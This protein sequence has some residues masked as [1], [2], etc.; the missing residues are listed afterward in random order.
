[1]KT[2]ILAAIIIILLAG[3]SAGSFW[4]AHILDK[5]Q[6]TQNAL[7]QKQ[8]LMLAQKLTGQATSTQSQLEALSEQEIN[9]RQQVIQ[10]S[11][12]QMLTDAVSKVTP[13][14][15]SIIISQDVPQ[16]QVVYEN[17][18][19][20][21]PFFQNSGMQIPVYQPTGKTQSQ[22]VGAGTG[23][24]ITSDG[25]ILTNKH[26]VPDDQSSYTVLLSSGKQLPAKVI[27]RD[28]NNDLAI[29]K[30]SGSGYAPVSLGDSG[31]LKL[32]QTVFAIGNALGQYSNSVSV[33]VISGLNR[34]IQAG[35]SELGTEQLSGIIQTDAAI[36][37]GNS[38]GP[39]SDLS[40]SVVGINVATVQGSNNI[41]F[42]IPINE[43]KQIIKSVIGK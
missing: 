24:V 9:N 34:S 12:D 18:F 1:M 39:L 16:Y 37:P 22:E 26:V 6:Q 40:G 30:I 19:G 36:N 8:I 14:V 29:I 2:K 20:D 31:G 5:K 43:V 23:F 33:G 32:G 35:G 25:Y 28:Q 4:Y 41:S 27:Y 3:A 38:G 21:D 10:K 42:S 13:S 15:V 7:L 17:P 11:Q